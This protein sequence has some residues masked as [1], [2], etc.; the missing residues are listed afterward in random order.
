MVAARMK[1]LLIV[2]CL[3]SFVVFSCA[4]KE[5]KPEKTVPEKKESAISYIMEDLMFGVFFDE[6]GTKRILTLG[7]DQKEFDVYIIVS[8]PE[9]MEIAA[10][11]WRIVLPEGVSIVNDK[12][13]FERHM[14]YGQMEHGLSE[15]FPCVK[16]PKLLLH[17][18][19]LRTEK[20]L[21]NAEV[22]VMS[23]EESEFLGV[24]EC[25]EGFPRARAAAYKA[26][27]NPM[28]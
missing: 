14:T 9:E 12:Y 5:E 13:Y 22:A 15:R 17:V 25:K 3:C 1:S 28:E 16:G 4:K 11:E 6:E 8:F 23:S 27:V 2:L 20:E 21:K 26:V 10:V 19:T 7:K 24:A 18:L